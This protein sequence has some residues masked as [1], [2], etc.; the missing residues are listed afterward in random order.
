[1]RTQTLSA[2]LASLLV[3]HFTASAATFDQWRGD[4]FTPAQ[5]SDSSVS[6]PNADPD[7]DGIRNYAEFVL[8]S[9]PWVRL[10]EP[11]LLPQFTIGPGTSL[12][13]FAAVF[14]V[15]LGAEGAMLMPQVTENLGTRW[16]ADQIEIYGNG[17]IAD[18]RYE[19]LAMDTE[20]S[21]Q[22][23][24]RFIRLLIAADAD[25]DGMPDDWELALGFDPGDPFDFIADADGDGDSN[26][27][28]FLHGTNPHNANDNR[29]RDE[30]PRAPRNASIVINS[31]GSRDV[32]WEDA[33][34]NEQF[35]VI[36]GTDNNGQK[37]ELGRVGPNHTRFHLPTGY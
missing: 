12:S 31:D 37:V 25:Q 35:F 6:G 24:H 21:N 14:R 30:I 29:R 36:F 18:G 7:G 13:H 4:H 11:L 3:M 23:E 27:V 16:R 10:T 17:Y 26:L 22:P 9:D 33:S 15:N 5:L 32:V 1:M 28:E 34:D 2:A 8:G 19:Y 20:P